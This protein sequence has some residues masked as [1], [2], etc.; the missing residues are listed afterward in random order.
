MNSKVSKHIVELF[1]AECRLC[2]A[3]IDILEE[4]L[5]EM[6]GIDF[7]VHKASECVDGKCCQLAASYGIFAV[8]S[9]VIDGKLIKT[10]VVKNF[11]E[12][13]SFLK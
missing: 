7:I 11:E 6:P 10:G 5:K 4:K 1:S 2:K 8:P 9:I 13:S 3:N 12:I